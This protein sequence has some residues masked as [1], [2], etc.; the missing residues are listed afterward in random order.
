M[1]APTEWCL[2]NNH[3]LNVKTKKMIVDFGKQQTEHTPIHIDRNAVEKVKS[4]KFLGIHITDHLKWSS[5]TDSVVK[6]QQRR[7]VNLWRLKIIWLKT[8]T[9][10]YSCKIKR[11]LSGCITA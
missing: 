7:L 2:E 11:I 1:R 10:V 3:V 5:H 6:E 8:L 4:F 9:N